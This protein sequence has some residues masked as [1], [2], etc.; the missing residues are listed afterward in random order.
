MGSQPA[1]ALSALRDAGTVLIAD[2][3]DFQ[4]KSS[5]E[6]AEFMLTRKQ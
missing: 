3:A 5:P 4:R 2:T 1:N 6:S